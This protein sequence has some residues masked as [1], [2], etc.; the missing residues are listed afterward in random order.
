MDCKINVDRLNKDELTYELK[1]RGYFENGPVE[2]LRKDLRC[3]L[4]A[5][6]TKSFSAPKYPFTYDEDIEALH[7]KIPEIEG[8]IETFSGNKHCGDFKK[9]ESQ[10]AHAMNRLNNCPAQTDKELGERSRLNFVLIKL[11]T[12]LNEKIKHPQASSPIK[13]PTENIVTN[14]IQSLN[15]ENSSISEVD[16]DTDSNSAQISN[17]KSTPVIKWNIKY[18]GDS[19]H[20]SLHGFLE[21]VD[22]LRIARNI[23]K[24]QLFRSAVDLFEGSALIWFR[25]NKQK[26]YNWDELVRELKTTFLPPFYE[27]HLFEEI[28]KRTQGQNENIAVYVSV[29]TSLFNRLGNKLKEEDQLKILLKNITP[30]YQQQLALQEIRSINELIAVCKKLEE[31]KVAIDEFVPPPSRFET[32]EAEYSYTERRENVT[33]AEIRTPLQNSTKKNSDLRCFKCQKLGHF[34]RDCRVKKIYCYKCKK[35]DVTIRS[36]TN[37]NQGNGS[38]V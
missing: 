32:F 26:F 2:K 16:S 15:L 29:M 12:E 11:E 36:C 38:R 13:S 10:L 9:I 20:L 21:R 5:E 33:V 3:A 24:E 19:K 28:R 14:A 30:F 1:I 6:K 17:M 37:C 35:P 22:E 27:E 7:V 34:A 31:R 18:S 23:T 25:A 4:K 8:L